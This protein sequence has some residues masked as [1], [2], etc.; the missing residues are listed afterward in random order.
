MEVIITILYGMPSQSLLI[1]KSGH[2][3]YEGDRYLRVNTQY[4]VLK[5]KESGQGVLSQEAGNGGLTVEITHNLG[6]KPLVSVTGFYFDL[7]TESVITR[8]SRWNRWFYQG[9]QVADTYRYYADNTKLYIVL[10]LSYL[11]DAYTFDLDFQYHIYY[12]EDSL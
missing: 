11:T 5:L 9:L 4:P 2:S 7:G 12:D 10:S 3:V 6:Y 8:Y 1:A